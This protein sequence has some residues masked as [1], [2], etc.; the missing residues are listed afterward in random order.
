MTIRL[1][2]QNLQEPVSRHI[3]RDFIALRQDETVQHAIASLRKHATAGEI[4][5]LYVIDDQ[6]RLVGI[7][8]VRALLT[9]EPKI[10]ISSIMTPSPISIL[11]TDTVFRACELFTEHRFL[12]LPVVDSDSKIAGIVDINLFTD[13]VVNSARLRQASNVFQ[14]IGV[15]ISLGKSIS[16]WA[17]FK[18]RFPWLLCNLSSGLV[19]ALIASS[20]E[21]LISKIAILAMF[22]TVV[23]AMAESVSIQSMT[24]TVQVLLQQQVTFRRIITGIRKEFFISALIGAVSGIVVGG[25]AFLWKGNLLQGVSIAVSILFAIVTACL[26]GVLLPTLVRALKVDPKIASGPIVLATADIATLLFYFTTANWLL[27]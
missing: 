4:L 21:L 17:G 9:A 25:V 26:L 15:H 3:R 7:V 19:C 23:L 1:K 18:S 27:G 8:P 5:Y 13:E 20:Y 22:I 6:S 16:S 12:A 10:Q 14:L 2:E 11:S 24:L